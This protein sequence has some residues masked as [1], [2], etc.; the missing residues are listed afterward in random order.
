MTYKITICL[1]RLVF[2]LP[3]RLQEIHST[4][5]H[6]QTSPSV[7]PPKSRTL[8]FPLALTTQ[9]FS[10]LHLLSF[11]PACNLK[12]ESNFL[13]SQDFVGY[14]TSESCLSVR[15][16]GEACRKSL[17][18]FLHSILVQRN[19]SPKWIQHTPWLSRKGS[20]SA[21]M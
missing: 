20:S 6:T 2:S 12:I 3:N 9:M 18:L 17:H 13:S 7:L 4:R 14:E 16:W 19:P 11:C 5:I 1:P 21:L 8:L 10:A 15:K